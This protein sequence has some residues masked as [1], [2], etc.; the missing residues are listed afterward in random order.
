MIAWSLPC[1]E[2]TSFEGDRE[3]IQGRLPPIVPTL[4]APTCWVQ[5]DD[6]HVQALQCGLLV[7]KMTS[8][9]DRPAEPGV[10]TLDRVSRIDHGPDL[11]M[12]AQERHELRPRVLPQLHDRRILR[13][14]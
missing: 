14:P 5:A 7:G 9:F 10:E 12:E 8:C 6:R 2:Y 4:T 11:G 1:C 13:F 3:S